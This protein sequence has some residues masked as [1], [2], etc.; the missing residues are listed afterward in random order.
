M[1]KTLNAEYKALPSLSPYIKSSR[2]TT[3]KED[4]KFFGQK[5]KEKVDP[6]QTLS[7]VDVGCGNGELLY[8]LK[9]QFP[10]WLLTGYDFTQEFIETGNKFEGLSGVKLIHMDMFDIVEKYDIVLCDGV[11]QIFSDIHKPLEK[12]ISICKKDG[13][14][15]ITGLF[16]KFDIEVRLQFCDNSNPASK[17]IWR[18]DFNQHSQQSIRRLIQK[19]VSSIEFESVVMDKDLPLNADMPLWNYTFRD[20]NNKNIITNGLN[21]IANKTMLIIN[22]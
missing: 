10:H 8:Y 20:A 11:I 9:N 18:A 15:L 14:A 3:P 2:Y 6:A 7:V 19:K 22:K 17:N 13:Y 12:I 21:I 4:H 1:S 5:L 16:N